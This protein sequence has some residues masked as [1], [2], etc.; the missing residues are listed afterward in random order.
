MFNWDIQ[1]S[2]TYSQWTV[3]QLSIMII[4]NCTWSILIQ[5]IRII[6]SGDNMTQKTQKKDP[7]TS[8]H[9]IKANLPHWAEFEILRNG[10]Y[11]A[12]L[13]SQVR[14]SGLIHCSEITKYRYNCM[15]YQLLLLETNDPV[16]G[17][18][19]LTTLRKPGLPCVLDA[20]VS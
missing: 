11:S 8:L 20:L 14:V 7:F 18:F 3:P 2:G 16:Y 17:C 10:A 5:Q 1:Y 4:Y 19:I 13:D 9:K 12:V 15:Y 6:L